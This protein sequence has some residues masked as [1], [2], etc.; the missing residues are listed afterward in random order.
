[1][2]VTSVV[3]QKGGVGKTTLSVG[4]AAALAEFGRRVLLIDLD[5]QG[6]A[7][8]ELLG[9]SETE[10]TA[11]SLARALSKSWKGPVADL[12]V[13]H[14]D[15]NVGNGGTFDVIPTSPTCSTWS[16]GSTSSG[17]PVGSSPGSYSSPTT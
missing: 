11:P 2:R 13:S 10:P 8:T 6:H 1:M 16:G 7:T 9:L 4:T 17:C 12:A 15:S 5:P 14:P 3:N